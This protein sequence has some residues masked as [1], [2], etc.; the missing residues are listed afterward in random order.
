VVALAGYAI[1]L[2]RG[3][4]PAEEGIPAARSP[5]YTA[6][7]YAIAALLALSG[8]IQIFHVGDSLWPGMYRLGGAAT[9][10]GAVG[11]LLLAGGNRDGEKGQWRCRVG[12][13]LMIL[14]GGIWLI[15]AYKDAATDPVLWRFA[16][17]ILAISAVLM[18]FY[19]MAGYYFDSPRPVYTLFFCEL[20]AFLGVMSAID[21]MPMAEALRFA[22]VALLLFLWGFVIAGNFPKKETPL[23]SDEEI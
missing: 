15:S 6:A 12:A 13:V 10:V 19:Y 23:Q 16:P 3:S 9:V 20:G 14:F 7:L 5:L 1:Y 4:T 21:D 8:V 2:R 17:E 18:A 22:A 11:L